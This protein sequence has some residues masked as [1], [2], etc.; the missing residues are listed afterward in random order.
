MPG[1]RRPGTWKCG[2]GTWN[3]PPD[4]ERCSRC[5]T[6]KPEKSKPRPRESALGEQI[7]RD[8]ER[9]QR[10]RPPSPQGNPRTRKRS[11]PS[12]ANTPL[13]LSI[14]RSVRQRYE[15]RKRREEASGDDGEGRMG[16]D[17]G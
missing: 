11:G 9:K 5:D 13:A 6:R 12:L 16:A 14:E 4:A 10:Q 1:G 2:C 17:D 15:E 7:R 8:V 3:V